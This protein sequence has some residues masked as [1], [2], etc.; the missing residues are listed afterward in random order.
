MDASGLTSGGGPS[1]ENEP[2]DN[3]RGFDVYQPPVV[4]PES[5]LAGTLGSARSPR[6]IAVLW[7]DLLG[8]GDPNSLPCARHDRPA[9]HRPQQC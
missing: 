5:W 1:P 2:T 8:L 7:S 4:R 3:F 6:A 9:A